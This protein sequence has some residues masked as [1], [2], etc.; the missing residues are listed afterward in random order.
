MIRLTDEEILKG[1]N[2]GGYALGGV[3]VELSSA[4][5]REYQ[6][7]AEAQLKKVLE[8]LDSYRCG[9]HSPNIK[10]L[11]IPISDWQALLEEA[12]RS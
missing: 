7:V 11:E 10:V 1:V 4:G 9:Q 12:N 2:D 8:E 3:L 5:R 6:G